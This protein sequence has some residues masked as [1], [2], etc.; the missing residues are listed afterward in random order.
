MVD[1]KKKTNEKHDEKLTSSLFLMFWRVTTATVGDKAGF[2]IQ[3]LFVGNG[4]D[5]EVTVK[6]GAGKKIE[7]IKGKVVGDQ[8]FGQFTVPEIKK[9]TEFKF[10]VKLAKLSLNGNSSNTLTVLPL[11]KLENAKWNKA[12]AK[13]GDVLKMSTQVTNAHDADPVEVEILQFDA[14]GAHLPIVTLITLVK[15]KKAEL[16]WELRP[17]LKYTKNDTGTDSKVD[18]ADVESEF[19]FKMRMGTVEAKSGNVKL[20]VLGPKAELKWSKTSVAP[21]HNSAWPPATP[22]TDTVPN[23]AQVDI[24]LATKNIPDDT[25]VV[26]EVR[27]CKTSALIPKGKI[28][29]LV[30]KG[31]KLI[32]PATNLAPVWVFEAEHTLWD[33]W[34]A[35][36]YFLVATFEYK[37]NG[38][39]L[40]VET[41]RDY[42][43]KPNDVL[44]LLYWHM[45][46]SD[47]IADTPAGGGLSTG[48]EMTEIA[49]IITARANH[50]VAQ[51][52]VNQATLPVNLWGSLLRNS[53]IY[54]HA[55]HGSVVDRT[56]AAHLNDG[57]NNPP[58][59]ALGNWRSVVMLGRTRL[60]DVEVNQVANVPSVPRY[61]VYM[62]TCVAGWEPSLGNAFRARGTQ[63]YLAFRKYIPDG[64]ARQMA[65][66]FYTKWRDQYQYNPDKI[67][68]VFWDVG[69]PYYGS[70]R[71]ILIGPDGGQI[72]EGSPAWKTTLIVVG[73]IAAAAVVGVGIYALGKQQKLW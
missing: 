21:N 43:A 7:T 32:D 13:Q 30:I 59:V 49:G 2:A 69:A 65:R 38:T 34:D 72:E 27:H 53:F 29:G 66:D 51:Q 40:C 5:I 56:T 52:A 71:P 11:L 58:T 26:V 14:R 37:V 63:H 44:R 33:P 55:S 60:G 41:P 31:D 42:A 8:F 39:K 36:F 6:D 4:A 25:G 48:A 68:S 19:F 35:P 3:T 50:S 24:N 17:N 23:D 70:M 67:A 57:T 10:S 61:F 64:D 47:A 28:E 54:H 16:T 62:D 1:H 9:K 18:Y 45:S 15:S 46:V 12:E 20:K 73:V 22:P